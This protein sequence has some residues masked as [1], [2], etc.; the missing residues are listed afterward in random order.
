[1]RMTHFTEKIFLLGFSLL[2]ANAVLAQDYPS[3]PIRLGTSAPGGGSDFTARL[4]AQGIAGPLGQQ[5]IVEN[6]GSPILAGEYVAKAAPDGY[7]LLVA[8]SATWIRPLFVKLPWDPVR[9]FVPITMVERSPNVVTVHP[10]MPVRSVKELIALAKA[11]PGELNF[12]SVASGGPDHLAAEL[13]KS[14]TGIKIS[15][16]P[17]KGIAPALQALLSGEV[18][19]TFGSIASVMPHVKSGR[20]RA[21]AVT[22]AEPSALLPALPPVAATVPGFEV[23]PV[24]GMWAPAKTPV[25]IIN[26]L[27]QE[28]VRFLRTPEAKERF[29]SAGIETVGNSPEEFA[30]IIKSEMAIMSRVIKEAGI[31]VE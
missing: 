8:G 4:V 31:K 7:T 23:V 19:L 13:L 22:S 10:S 12:G 28:I 14:M 1:M 3:K 6:R 27:N 24:T 16:V 26:R 30:A 9:D 5:V 20:L 21:I 29:L 17:Y 15:H 25:A 11:R 2:G 18:Q